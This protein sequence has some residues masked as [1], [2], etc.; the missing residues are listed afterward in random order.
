M[1]ARG[2]GRCCTAGADDIRWRCSVGL[3]LCPRA[4]LACCAHT[5][6]WPAHPPDTAGGWCIEWAG[7]EQRGHPA[8]LPP[9]VL[10]LTAA[11]ASLDHERAARQP[12]GLFNRLRAAAATTRSRPAEEGRGGGGGSTAAAEG[13]RAWLGSW[14][15]FHGVR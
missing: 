9:A 5:L 13:W 10:V 11:F 7:E 14:K 8:W 1:R 6:A 4:G 12:L 15:R 2:A 3:L